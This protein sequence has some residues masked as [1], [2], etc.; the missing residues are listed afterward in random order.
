MAFHTLSLSNLNL[1]QPGHYDISTLTSSNYKNTHAGQAL[2]G[3]SPDGMRLIFSE[4][5]PG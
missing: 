3:I 1:K 4:I 5:Y 2:A